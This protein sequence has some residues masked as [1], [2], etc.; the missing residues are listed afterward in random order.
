MFLSTNGSVRGSGEA[1]ELVSRIWR[2][3]GGWQ[4]RPAAASG[5]GFP[6]WWVPK[7]C[8]IAA[9]CYLARACAA[10]CFLVTVDTIASLWVVFVRRIFCSQGWDRYKIE[11][12]AVQYDWTPRQFIE[13][14]QTNILFS[15]SS[16]LT[17]VHPC[18]LGR[19][20]DF[21]LGN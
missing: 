14:K 15:L 19:W 8:E 16:A 12:Y 13:H 6:V 18:S 5:V 1:A 17:F 21:T 4:G 9:L 20:I 2:F 3:D 7:F 10:L 11:K